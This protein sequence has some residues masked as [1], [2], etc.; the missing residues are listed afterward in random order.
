MVALGRGLET[1][2]VFGIFRVT[3]MESFVFI[4]GIL[5]ALGI[6]GY[7]NVREYLLWRDFLR[8]YGNEK[9]N[10]ALNTDAVRPPRAG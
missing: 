3:Y 5:V 9:P 8:K 4:C 7:L 1:T 10:P 6:A 2:P